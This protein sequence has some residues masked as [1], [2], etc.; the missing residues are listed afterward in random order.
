M[1]QPRGKMLGGCSSI[2]AMIYQHGSPEDFDEWETKGAHGWNYAALK[3][4]GSRG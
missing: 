1:Y 3:V 2:N 4:S